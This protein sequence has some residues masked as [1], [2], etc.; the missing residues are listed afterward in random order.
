MSS[1]LITP[2]EAAEMLGIAVAT[3]AIWRTRGFGPPHMKFGGRMVRYSE[4]DVRVFIERRTFQNTAE[5][6][7]FLKNCD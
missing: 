3:L 4:S 7:S 6:K 1:R 2:A 5:S